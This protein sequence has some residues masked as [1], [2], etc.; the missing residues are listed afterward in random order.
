MSIPILTYHLVDAPPP[1]RSPGRGLWVRPA[2]FARQM[3]LMS[4]LGFRGLS[5]RDLMP[6]VRG[7]R[8]G[9]VFGITFDDGFRCVHTHAMPVLNALGFTATN[10]FV[11][12]QLG[13]S[14]VWDRDLGIRPA[15]LMNIDEMR[16]WHAA[17]HEVGSHTL[18]HAD[19]LRVTLSEGRRQIIESRH[20]IEDA[21]QAPVEGFCYPYGHHASH[22][23]QMVRDAGYLHATSTARGLARSSDDPFGLPRISVFCGT[24]PLRFLRKC[25]TRH[26]DRGREQPLTS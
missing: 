14:N 2:S 16:E 17:G 10:Y 3:R 22:H 18:D 23:Q 15:A 24:D 13:G 11:A 7:E 26:E 12:R 5:V 19:L 21:L 8:Q 6:Y 9:Q 20:V 1:H 25:L 4:W